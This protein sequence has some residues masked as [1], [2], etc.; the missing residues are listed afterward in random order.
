MSRTSAKTA[1]AAK[2]PAKPPAKRAKRGPGRPTKA[3]QLE[4]KRESIGL[5]FP[6]PNYLLDSQYYAELDD[7]DRDRLLQW[8][9]HIRS[10]T[11]DKLSAAEYYAMATIMLQAEKLD[12]MQAEGAFFDA[13]LAEECRRSKVAVMDKMEAYR[14]SA[15]NRKGNSLTDIRK[16]FARIE[17]EDGRE[18]EITVAEKKG[19]P[20]MDAKYTE[21]ID[22][23]APIV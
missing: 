1:P 10:Y 14:D 22:L 5:T 6:I 7:S 12:I 23:D 13:K 4:N 19:K 2:P 11:A 16:M 18:L 8:A 15:K 20:A 3:K 21:V 17:A 9:D